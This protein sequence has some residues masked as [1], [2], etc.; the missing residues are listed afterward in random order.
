MTENL[1]VSQKV[2]VGV[3]A[4]S[5]PP[6]GYRWSVEYLTVAE[7]KARKWLDGAQY[8]HLV[9]QVLALAAEEDPTH[10]QSLDVKSIEDF[11]ELRERGG[12]LGSL[13]VRV[14]FGIDKERGSILILGVERKGSQKARKSTKVRM[15]SRWKRYLR[16]KRG[17][18][19]K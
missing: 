6:P 14:F 9:D 8:G 18:T 4:G 11:F 13:V 15:R 1:A 3:E 7:Q 12:P 2:K 16:G 17:R 19:D 10:A 5:G